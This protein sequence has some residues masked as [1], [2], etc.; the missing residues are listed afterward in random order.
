MPVTATNPN[1]VS[2]LIFIGYSITHLLA[3]SRF[4]RNPAASERTLA[5]TSRGSAVFIS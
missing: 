5:T 2:A 3:S 4:K 1:I